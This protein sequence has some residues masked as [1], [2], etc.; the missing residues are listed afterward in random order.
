MSSARD[1][2]EPSHYTNVRKPLPEAETLPAWCYT[3]P[4]F[5][6][7]EV[8]EIFLKVWIFI[9]RADELPEAGDYASVDT[10]GGPVIIVRGRNGTLRAH[11]NNCRH[12]GSRLLYGKGNCKR[13]I[14]C[15]YHAWTYDLD[16]RL[17][18]APDMERT[19]GFDKA[20]YRLHP[21]RLEVWDG[22][23]F[24]N[25]NP[26]CESLIEYLGDM[27]ERFAPYGFSDWVCVRRSVYDLDCN[28]K[29]LIENA[30]EAYHTTTVHA[31]SLGTQVSEDVTTDGNWEALYLPGETSVSILPGET[32]PFPH[33]PNLPGELAHGAYFTVIYPNTQFACTQDSMWWLTFTPVGPGR[34]R[35]DFGFAFPRETVAQPNF[36]KDVEEYYRR[37]DMGIA[38]DNDT[39]QLQQRGLESVLHVPGPYS[40]RERVVHLLINWIL[41]RVLTSGERA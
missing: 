10:A 9:C 39:G 16:G 15:P 14:M 4:A 27:P 37:W 33:V 13:A 40:Y 34:C 22:F 8:E 36:A 38:E 31:D 3:D 20:N 18:G 7:R 6:V 29:L 23:V 26:A 41:D 30:L 5:T 19:A 12:R 2:F 35:A 28:W 11:A 1:I 17:T 21:V 24:I 25:F 32:A